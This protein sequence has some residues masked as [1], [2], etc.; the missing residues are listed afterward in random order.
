MTWQTNLG[1]E[2]KY[3]IITVLISS[4]FW[5]VLAFIIEQNITAPEYV[6]SRERNGFF[7]TIA[8][9]YI[10]RLSTWMCNKK[11]SYEERECEPNDLMA[12]MYEGEGLRMVGETK[13]GGR[14]MVEAEEHRAEQLNRRK[15]GKIQPTDDR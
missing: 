3:L 15:A 2:S 6:Y 7:L 9:F 1:R 14:Q 8:F 4:L 13:E 10:L 12:Q 5:A 11:D